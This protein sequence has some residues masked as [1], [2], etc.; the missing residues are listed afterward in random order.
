ML[1]SVSGASRGRPIGF[2]LR[3][4]LA[5]ALDM[6]AN[7]RFRIM[8]RSNSANTPIIW[9]IALP[10]GVDVSSARIESLRISDAGKERA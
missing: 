9:N 2:P 3:V 7:T 10:D 1:A 4:P 5:A 8:D 6:P